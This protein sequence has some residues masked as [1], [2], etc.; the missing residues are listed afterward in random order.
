[1]RCSW[2]SASAVPLIVL[3]GCTANHTL[4]LGITQSAPKQEIVLPT[5]DRAVI[6]DKVGS[7]PTE[8]FKPI[9]WANPG[10]GSAGV[11]ESIAT[12]TGLDRDCRVFI[13]TRQ[14]LDGTD[15]V[16]GIACRSD[17]KHWTIDRLG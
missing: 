7:A 1:M 16:R 4:D 14:K 6:A 17:P 12:D 11:I 5:D 8:V 9:P 10:T 15:R 3:M 13:T 2:R